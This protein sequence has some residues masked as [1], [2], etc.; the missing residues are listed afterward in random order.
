M[1]ER[2]AQKNPAG[3][4]NKGA[5]NDVAINGVIPAIETIQAFA[6]EIAQMSGQA[7]DRTTQHIEKL[8]VAH[9]KEEAA[10][11]QADFLRESMDHAVQHTR[12]Y[13]LMLA[14]F[15]HELVRPVNVAVETAEAA[16]RATAAKVRRLS[17]GAGKA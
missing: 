16:G 3:T 17:E 13:I 1:A 9:S 12:K 2:S 7:L 6:R 11:I 10:A 4:R 14:T 5:A 15:P 8:R